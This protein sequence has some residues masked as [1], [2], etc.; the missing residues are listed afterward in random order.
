MSDTI[1]VSPGATFYSDFDNAPVGLVGTVGVRLLRKSDDVEIMK[2]T[3][4]GIVETPVGSGR[5]KATLIAPVEQGEYTVLWDTGT[6]KSSASDDLVVTYHLPGP[7]PTIEAEG[8]PSPEQLRAQSALLTKR[9]PHGDPGDE[10]LELLAS[11]T[12]VLVG[13]MTGRELGGYTA[14]IPPSEPVPPAMMPLAIRDIAMKTEQLVLATGTAKDRKR[15]VNRANMAGF[16]AGH[17]SETYFGP[18]QA[19]HEQR[20]D[21]DPLLHEL[22]WALCTP[23]MQVYWL[24]FWD[25]KNFPAGQATIE[26]FDYG[27]R[28]N[29][30]AGTFPWDQGYWGAWW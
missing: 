26:S 19:L 12:S 13:A 23:A 4:A 29:Y 24:Q 21:P 5:Y 20:L 14:L 3:T 1:Y 9:F 16:H 25:P 22:L 28:P 17:Y 11:I 10:E 27:N 15:S 8:V 2:R 6:L 18:K 7:L 30:S